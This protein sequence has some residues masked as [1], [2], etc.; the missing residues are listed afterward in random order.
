MVLVMLF[1]VWL[2]ALLVHRHQKGS[3]TEANEGVVVGGYTVVG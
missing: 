2:A 1:V 3:A